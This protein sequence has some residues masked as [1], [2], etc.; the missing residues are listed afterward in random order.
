MRIKAGK[1]EK[2][3]RS[4]KLKYKALPDDIIIPV[5]GPTGVGKSTFI[6]HIA[7]NSVKVGHNL[8]SCTAEL[9]PVVVNSSQHSQLGGQRLVIVDTP[10]FDD[11]YVS[12]SEILQRIA[13]WLADAYHGEMKLGGVIYLHDISL[14]RMLGTT[15]KNLEVFQKLCGDDAFRSVILGTTKWGDVFKEDGDRRTQQLCDNYWREMLDHGSKVFRFEDSSKSAWAMVNSIIELNRSR[16]EVLQIQRELVDA[17]KLIPDTEAGQKLR[18][19]LDQ[20]LIKLKEDRKAQKKDESKRME[21]DREIAQVREQMKVMKVPVSQRILGFLSL[22]IDKILDAVA[23]SPPA[24]ES[25]ITRLA[26]D[27]DR[28]VLLFGENREVKNMLLKLLSAQGVDDQNTPT[29]EIKCWP[30]GTNEESYMIIDTPDLDSSSNLGRVVQKTRTWLE[31]SCRE[32]MNVGVVYLKLNGSASDTGAVSLQENKL[33]THAA[34]SRVTP[35]PNESTL[36]LNES[37]SN[38]NIKLVPNGPSNPQTARQPPNPPVISMTD[39]RPFA[40]PID[41][42]TDTPFPPSTAPVF[43]PAKAVR[44]SSI[45]RKSY[46]TSPPAVTKEGPPAAI[47]SGYEGI[48]SATTV[49]RHPLPTNQLVSSG[50]VSRFLRSKGPQATPSPTPLP[51]RISESSPLTMELFQGLPSADSILFATLTTRPKTQTSEEAVEAD[52]VPYNHASDGKVVEFHN[53]PEAAQAM[54]HLLLK[55]TLPVAMLLDTLNSLDEETTSKP[56]EGGKFKLLGSFR[57]LFR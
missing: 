7:G 1:T 19:D 45:T 57:S 8:K 4:T 16:A 36:S 29:Q 27:C 28:L 33:P 39:A 12:D 47:V 25:S 34:V 24:P 10:G 18:N 21:L 48:T 54:L 2:A 26:I 11:T 32:D 15:R 40:A 23:L 30:V 5:M 51:A 13:L 43:S 37:L 46:D 17:L 55:K 35:R 42:K 20:V 49:A 53:T 6:N 56:S 9:Q 38:Y 3:P 31:S 44:P 50:H 41:M 14:S 52:V 22:G